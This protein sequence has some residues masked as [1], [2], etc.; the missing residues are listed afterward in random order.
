MDLHEEVSQFVEGQ[1]HRQRVL[2]A[3]TCG[4]PWQVG[5]TEV[6]EAREGA[7]LDEGDGLRDDCPLLPHG[8]FNTTLQC[9]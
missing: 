6:L 8:Q 3:R 9:L 4:G 2:G 7:G 1:G 5:V